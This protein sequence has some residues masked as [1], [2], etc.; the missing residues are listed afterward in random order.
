MGAEE[1]ADEEAEE[2][3]E[4]ETGDKEDAAVEPIHLAASR[5][6]EEHPESAT[7]GEDENLEPEDGEEEGEV[8]PINLM[9]KAKGAAKAAAKAVKTVA[10][11]AKKKA[12]PKK[13][14]SKA[15]A[16]AAKAASKFSKPK[17]KLFALDTNNFINFSA[18]VLIGA[19][20]GSGVTIT[21]FRLYGRLTSTAGYEPLADA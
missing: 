2:K 6:E 11:P 14:A 12:A 3:L 16:A 9:A 1:K 21:I 4:S 10:A 15:A 18:A 8:E 7:A 20:A 5:E 19:F 17:A 13:T